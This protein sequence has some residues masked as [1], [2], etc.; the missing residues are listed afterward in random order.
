M[1]LLASRAQPWAF[2]ELKAELGL[3]DGN[4]ISHLRTLEK[5]DSITSKKP[6]EKVDL[7][8]TTRYQK[9]AKQLLIA[10]WTLWK[11]LSN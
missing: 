2:Q 6:R 5:S 7:K 3:S 8:A 9:A 11:R 10:T 4:L 1:S